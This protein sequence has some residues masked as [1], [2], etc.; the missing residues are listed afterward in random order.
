MPSR[1]HRM[2]G[3][4]PLTPRTARLSVSGMSPPIANG[5]ASGAAA[6]AFF[7]D[8]AYSPDG[9]LLATCAEK[10][11]RL[12][13]VAT[14]RQV[15]T[16]TGPTTLAALS[17]RFSPDG[18]TLASGGCDN[19]V[20]LW[21][22]AARRR[23]SP[24]KGTWHGSNP[25]PSHRMA[26]PWPRPA[27]IA[28][29]GFGTWPP[30]PDPRGTSA[31]TWRPSIRSPSR[32]TVSSWPRAAARGPCGSGTLRRTRRRPCSGGIRRSSRL[33]P[34]RRT[35]GAWSRATGTAWSRCG[36][37]RPRPTRTS[38]PVPGPFSR[39]WRCPPMARPWP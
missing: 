36:T 35:A 23:S 22:V 8:L 11:I 20:R 32:P 25:W 3:P 27:L 9:T 13:D 15:A 2:A 26:R 17:I 31:G 21:D 28:R 30:P 5:R 10:T 37:S 1:S 33:W 4:S 7:P 34:S 14:G 19:R 39:P 6:W 24:W 18:K 38:W 12:W 29:C 16:L